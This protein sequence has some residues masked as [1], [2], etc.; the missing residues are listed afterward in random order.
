LGPVLQR[1][2]A[3]GRGGAEIG[4]SAR[5]RA[6][7]GRQ[8]GGAGAG[9]GALDAGFSWR[10]DRDPAERVGGNLDDSSLDPFWEVASARRAALSCI[11]LHLRRRAPP[12]TIWSTRVGRLADTT[13]AVARLL[14]SGI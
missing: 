1:A 14:F 5:H 12:I 10:D 8:A 13:I 7:A 3:A 4:V 11:A 2:H 6:V 9:R